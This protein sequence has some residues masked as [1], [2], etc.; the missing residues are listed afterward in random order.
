MHKIPTVQV[1]YDFFLPMTVNNYLN[2][3]GDV[4]TLMSTR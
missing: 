1:Q 4:T 3:N 2:T